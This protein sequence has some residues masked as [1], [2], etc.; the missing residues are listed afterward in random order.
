MYSNKQCYYF[1]VYP[2]YNILGVGQ[3]QSD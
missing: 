1:I 2:G 3:L